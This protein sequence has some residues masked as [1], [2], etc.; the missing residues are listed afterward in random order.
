MVN[1]RVAIHPF[2]FAL[3]PTLSGRP[4]FLFLLL[5]GFLRPP[6]GLEAQVSPVHAPERGEELT[7]FLMTMGPGE[8]VWERFGHNAIWIRDSLRGTDIAYNYGMF[9]FEQENF[10]LRFIQGKMDYWMEGFDAIAMANA[11]AGVGRSVLAQ[12][13]NLTP[14]QRADLR[15]F[16][17]WN[18]LP[19]NRFYRYDY[20]RD[21]CATRIR[22]AIDRVLGGQIRRATEGLR[23]GT[24]YRSHTRDLTATDPALY[25]AL[26]IGLAQPVDR[27]IS[28]WEEMFLP[29]QMS[30]TF[31]NI[32]VDG[33]GGANLPLVRSEQMLFPART[34][35]VPVPPPGTLS[36]LFVGV[37]LGLAVLVTAWFGS[38]RRD[39]RLVF[40]VLATGWGLFAGILGLVLVI[41]WTLTDHSVTYRNE[42]LFFLNPLHLWIGGVALFGGARRLGQSRAAMAAGLLI[43]ALSVVGTLVQ[44]LPAFYQA[45]SEIVALALPVNLAL[46]IALYAL[47]AETS[48]GRFVLN[49][50]LARVRPARTHV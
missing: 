35:T 18:A 32:T 34:A 1:S 25:T 45:N 29:I 30:E 13:L 5:I 19:Q 26:M 40:R 49:E 21:N 8:A 10:I 9:S 7:V 2:L 27:E 14:E 36:Y 31:R 4:A 43:A 15:D 47:Y 33:P 24:T 16:L 50:W 37:V 3:I 20:Y 38:Q 48:G 11:Y 28:E 17:E 23:S 12:E 41:L 42:N 46:A 6:T 44:L 39:A 22:D